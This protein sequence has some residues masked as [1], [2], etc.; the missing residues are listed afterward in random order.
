LTGEQTAV[1][2]TEFTAIRF[3]TSV[4]I[5]VTKLGMYIKA[6]ST[7]YSV[8]LALYGNNGGHPGALL[9]SATVLV[10]AAG[11]KELSLATPVTIPA[12]TYFVGAT[13]S[14]FAAYGM[15]STIGN[16]EYVKNPPTGTPWNPAGAPSPAPATA[17]FTGSHNLYVVGKE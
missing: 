6:F 13:Q 7:Q 16:Y 10:T 8:W 17:T 15:S 11:A 12:G 5:T 2:A 9:G 4:P 14:G 1:S 3:D